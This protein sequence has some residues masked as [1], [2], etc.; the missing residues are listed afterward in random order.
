MGYPIANR[1]SFLDSLITG[2]LYVAL[3]TTAP[4]DEGVGGVE[5]T[6]GGYTRIAHSAW[7]TA[8]SGVKANN[9]EIL[10]PVATVAWGTVVAA[11]VMDASTGG[12]QIAVSDNSFS[13]SVDIADTVRFQANELSFRF[14]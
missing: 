2:T 11:T 6:G 13:T 4:D 5:V 9:T 14:S 8:T 12:S 3:W 10:F 1:N 7:T